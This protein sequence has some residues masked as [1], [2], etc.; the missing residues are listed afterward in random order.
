MIIFNKVCMN[1][2][3]LQVDVSNFVEYNF[4]TSFHDFLPK[5]SRSPNLLLMNVIRPY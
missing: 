4:Y 3:Q 5:E 2:K 1:N